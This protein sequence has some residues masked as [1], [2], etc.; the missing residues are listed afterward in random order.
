MLRLANGLEI[1]RRQTI[2]H[3]YRLWRI[4]WII[5]HLQIEEIMTE[6]IKIVPSKSITGFELINYYFL[7]RKLHS[8]FEDTML[9]HVVEL[10][11]NSAG[12][13]SLHI[14]QVCGKKIG[15]KRTV[16]D[17]HRPVAS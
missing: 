3:L 1:H 2:A 5:L 16:C 7:L 11:V 10:L 9:C 15:V 17:F 12:G 14:L 13:S 8:P 4:E 6:K